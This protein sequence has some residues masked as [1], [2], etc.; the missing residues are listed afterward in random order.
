MAR[1]R[2]VSQRNL[3]LT[4]LVCTWA[5]I[6]SSKSNSTALDVIRCD[7]R[8]NFRPLCTRGRVHSSSWRLSCYS[9]DIVRRLQLKQKC[10][11]RRYGR[12]TTFH[13]RC[14]ADPRGMSLVT[15][16]L[17]PLFSTRRSLTGFQSWK[18]GTI[19]RP[20]FSPKIL[21]PKMHQNSYQ[22]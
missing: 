19:R 22:E 15:M 18:G 13:I 21:S 6:F 1:A 3:S 20:L 17:W 11:A 10:I 2:V 14:F 12:R 4:L 7:A 5:S 8:L 16:R 9:C